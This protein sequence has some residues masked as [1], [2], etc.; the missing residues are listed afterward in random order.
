MNNIGRWLF[1]LVLGFAVGPLSAQTSIEVKIKSLDSLF[2]DAYN[3][4]D[5]ALQAKMYN[6]S[7]VFMHDK[8][9]LTTSKKEIISS[10]VKYICGK[11]ERQLI[12]NSIE[13]YPIKDYGAIE[14]GLH[15]F[16]NKQE[17]SY[18]PPYKFILFWKHENG[19]WTIEKVVSLHQ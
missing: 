5:T 15:R 1:I 18:S 16:Y 19:E 7:I 10:T 4:C 2:F 11:V 9:G 17:N 6:D 3:R 13:V 8:D 12:E 14:I